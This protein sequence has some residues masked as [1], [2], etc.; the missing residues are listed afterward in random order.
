MIRFVL[1]L[2]CCLWPCLG[3]AQS[4]TSEATAVAYFSDVPAL[5]LP[6]GFSE[7][8]DEAFNF[9]AGDTRIVEMAATGPGQGQNSA[10]ITDF[11]EQTLPAL[12]WN[13]VEPG[14]FVRDRE[15]LTFKTEPLA[16]DLRLTIRI[17]PKS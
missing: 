11:Y 13:P 16:G 14:R 12:G 4:L 7:N 15:I 17:I 5:P 3:R 9:E 2:L 6:P 10:K 8:L 1:I